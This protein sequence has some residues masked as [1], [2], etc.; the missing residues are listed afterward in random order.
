MS[1]KISRSS[2]YAWDPKSYLQF[3][4]HRTRPAAELIA[5][6][7]LKAPKEIYDLG[8]GPGNS[9][10]LLRRRWPNAEIT[11]VDSSEDM[12]LGAKDLDIGARWQLENIEVWKPKTKPHLIFSNAALQ[13]LGN[14]EALFSRLLGFLKPGGVLAVQMPR[15]FASPSHAVIQQ[16]VED[17]PWSDRLKHVRPF[18]PMAQSE[19]Y[20]DMLADKAASIDIWETEYVHVLTGEDAVFSWLSATALLPFVSELKGRERSGFVA[21][22]RR[23]LGA[24]YRPRDDN[25]TLFPFRRLF[26]VAAAT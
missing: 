11:G 7:K 13:W 22:C 23:E 3:E 1:D 6:I 17:G 10:S 2:T 24:V 15:A 25:V 14:H 9:T 16:A 18:R 5:R 20:Y 26:I 12:L 19:D 4:D 8:C 21:R